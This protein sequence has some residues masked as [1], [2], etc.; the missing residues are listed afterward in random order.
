MNYYYSKSRHF[1]TIPSPQCLPNRI[2][3]LYSA[4]IAMC[5]YS[6]FSG[7]SVYCSY[8]FP[9]SATVFCVYVCVNT[10]ACALRKGAT[11]LYFY[12][13]GSISRK[14]TFVPDIWT[15]VNH[16]EIWGIEFNAMNEWAS[17]IREVTGVLL[18]EVLR[19]RW[20]WSTFNGRNQLN[21]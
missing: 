12:F 10:H 16:P 5:S 21:N 1:L 9:C 17:V 8:S 4:V 20:V 11:N 15:I 3:E 13:K 18:K 19:R 6:F 7:R 2:S 14:I